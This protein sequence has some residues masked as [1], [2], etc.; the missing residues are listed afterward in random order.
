MTTILLIRHAEKPEGQSQGVNDRGENDPDSLTPRGWQR[1]GALASFFGSAGLAVPDRIY[2]SARGKKKVAP[3]VKIGSKSNRPLE[4]V[5]PLAAKL[6]KS[7]IETFA[8]GEEENLAEEMAKL[9][10]VTLICWQHEG[11]PQIAKL[12][13]GT[14]VGVPDPWPGDRYDVVWSLTRTGLAKPWA[15]RQ[16]CQ[17]LLA[18]DGRDPI[19]DPGEHW[20]SAAP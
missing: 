8:K 12:I 17:C 9:D 3:G 20:P 16:I 10:G 19:A 1:A 18:G 5:T 15:F 4:T 11:I 13:L 6:N 2:V 7:P 14:E